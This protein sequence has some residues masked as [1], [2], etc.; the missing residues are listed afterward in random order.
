MLDW[1]FPLE[2]EWCEA[3]IKYCHEK[4]DLMNYFNVPRFDVP[5]LLR[6]ADDTKVW[7]DVWYN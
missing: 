2:A 4:P 3:R 5:E 7:R 1:R 6:N